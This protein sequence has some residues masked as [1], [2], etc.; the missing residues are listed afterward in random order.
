VPPDLGAA[1]ADPAQRNTIKIKNKPILFD[2]GS[3]SLS[4]G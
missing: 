2:I 1:N 4:V 3:P